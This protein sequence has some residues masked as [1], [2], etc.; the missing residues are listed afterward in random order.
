MRKKDLTGK[1]FGKLVAIRDIGSRQEGKRKFRWW[2]CKCD[3]G[4]FTKVRAGHLIGGQTSCGCIK[5]LS[6]GESQF[7]QVFERYK[8]QARQRGLDFKLGKRQFKELIS[9]DCFYCG[10]IPGSIQHNQKANGDYIYSGVDRIDNS[11]GYIN[12]NCVPCCKICNWMKR[13]MDYGEFI[14]HVKKICIV[15]SVE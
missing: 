2:L 6:K 10:S 13:T 1:R 12:K 7:N 5:I 11:I 14:N 3:C 4:K 9:S 8:R 15:S